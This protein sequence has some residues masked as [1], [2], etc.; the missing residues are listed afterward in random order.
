MC[1]KKVVDYTT[2]GTN[3]LALIRSYNSMSYNRNEFPTLMGV[4]WRTNFDRY[5]RVVSASQATAERPDGQVLNF[6]LSGGTGTP[7]SD[8]DV[9][10]TYSGSTYTLTD[11]DDVVETYTVTSGKGVISTI[12][13]PNGYTQ[14]FNYT[15]GVLTSVS[16]SYSRSLS[17]TYT[18]GVLTG[19]STPDSAT[20]TYGYTTTAG[21]SL[22][23][24]ITYNT[25]PS[26]SQTYV[27]G[28]TSYPFM[29]TGITDENGNSFASYTYDGQGRCTMSE[30]AG[31]A[32]E[33]QVAYNSDGTVGVTGPL[34]NVETYTFTTSNNMSKVTKIVRT[35]NSPVVSATR[36]FTYDAN[37]YLA[38]ATDWNGK[39][40]KWTNNSH[41]QPTS[42]T[43]A[44][45]DTLA[46]TTTISYDSTWV[47]KPYTITKTNV[48]IDEATL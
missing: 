7:D 42:F 33:V 8:V 14:T 19:V 24:S 28:N 18:S 12:A 26:T 16:D 23:T 48:T 35:A 17:F 44:Y 30:H 9:K 15:S 5:I 3:K 40:T 25:S 1:M 22:L 37:G 38:T 34:G 10:L 47:H 36:N 46:R 6:A 11:S 41:G 39:E 32:D 45:G 31:G 21:Q 43:E 29:L 4:N 20:L 27:Y 13:Y 2:V